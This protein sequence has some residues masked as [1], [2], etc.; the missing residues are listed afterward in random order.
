MCLQQQFLLIRRKRVV[1]KN[2]CEIFRDNNYQSL[3]EN[4]KLY[5]DIDWNPG[6]VYVNESNEYCYLQGAFESR[7]KN[8]NSCTPCVPMFE[9]VYG[10][11]H[12]F[13]LSLPE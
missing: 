3:Y 2:R 8:N 11:G 13:V 10:I 4:I 12:V 7:K 6:P 5:N 9:I 1:L